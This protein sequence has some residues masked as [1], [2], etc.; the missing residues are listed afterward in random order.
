MSEWVILDNIPSIEQRVRDEFTS[1]GDNRIEAREVISGAL[2]SSWTAP[3]DV[4]SLAYDEDGNRLL[5][6]LGAS[7][8]VAAYDLTAFLGKAGARGPP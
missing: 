6:G 4:A 8:A 7:G 5:V 3:G 1:A 2:V